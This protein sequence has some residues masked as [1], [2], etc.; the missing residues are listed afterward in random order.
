MLIY[1]Q[2]GNPYDKVMRS[3]KGGKLN[4]EPRK[5]FKIWSETVVGK[6]RMWNDENIETASVLR[7]VYGKF[8]EVW[9]QR[10]AALTSS[11]LT[12]LL[13]SNASHEGMHPVSMLGQLL[14]VAL[15]VRTPLNHI[16]N[17][18]EMALEG[19]LDDDT[20]ESLVRSHSASRALVHVINDLLD[21]TRTQTGQPLFLQDPLDLSHTIDEAVAIHRFE[22]QRKGIAFEVIENPSGT[23]QT[24]LGDRGKIRQIVANVTANAVKHTHQGKVTVEWGEL[25]KGTDDIAEASQDT[26][27][28]GIAI[29]D[30]GVGIPELQLEDMFRTFEQVEAE[31]PDKQPGGNLGLGLAVVARIVSHLG[32]QLRV[33][34]KVGHGSKFTFVLHFRLPGPDNTPRRASTSSSTA[35]NS[36][37]TMGEEQQQHEAGQELG[38]HSRRNSGQLISQSGS[39]G[40]KGTSSS[41]RSARS[42][43][44]KK[45][46]IDSLVQAI[47]G[48]RALAKAET[49]TNRPGVIQIG[50]SGTPLRPVKV[51][52]TE[53]DV[54]HTGHVARPRVDRRQTTH[55]GPSAFAQTGFIRAPPRRMSSSGKVPNLSGTP[56]SSAQQAKPLRIMIVED[57]AI[58]RAILMKKL[59]KDF[60]HDV[61]STVHGEDAVR[62]YST[63]N[64]FDIILMDLQ[65]VDCTPL[66]RHC[67]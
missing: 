18:L 48:D 64:N 3:N 37:M 39:G 52:E 41:L 50:D 10:E 63:D 45:S 19:P 53:V 8:I 61:K 26:I 9:R 32:G 6:S 14:T 56:S 16:I 28:I 12:S 54:P 60:N 36:S 24:L 42:R 49:R 43:E 38:P 2:A 59:K 35:D 21:L 55:D 30:T 46:E 57:D 17:Y 20:R 65:Y 11:K 47:G 1:L 44:S 22:A 33:E 40:S 67:R 58:N 66:W 7:L 51:D 29:S 25:P 62:L 4:L 27:K 15:T 34:S 31:M 5:S 23:P 13:L